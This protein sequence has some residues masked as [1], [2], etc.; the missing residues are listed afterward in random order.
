LIAMLATLV[1]SAAVPSAAQAGSTPDPVGDALSTVQTTVAETTAPV[2]QVADHAGDTAQPAS[3]GIQRPSGHGGG[4]PVQ[5]T[6]APIAQTATTSVPVAA[7]TVTP[8]TRLHEHARHQVSSIAATAS[9]ERMSTRRAAH[10]HGPYGATRHASG[11]RSAPAHR[12]PPPVTGTGVAQQHASAAPARIDRAPAS[13]APGAAASGSSGGLA[14]GGAGFALL[15]ATLLLAGPFLRRRLALLPA[16]C[17][18]VAFLVV[19][20][21]P[22]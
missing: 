18:P 9:D 17:R 20:E 8:R 15:V 19:L 12:P 7:T 13:S 6:I 21:R 16:V 14:S 1:C 10:G 3:G 2:R 5:E 22:G 11:E 4:Q